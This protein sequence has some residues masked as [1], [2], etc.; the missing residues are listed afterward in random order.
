M[1]KG[2]G[3]QRR[4]FLR[5][6]CSLL[7]ATVSATLAALVASPVLSP[8][9]R[10]A[11]TRARTA[12]VRLPELMAGETQPLTVSI[13]RDDGWLRSR[14]HRVVYCRR[15]NDD[16]YTVLSARC[17]HLGCTVA[18]DP[19]N[20]Q[21]KCPCHGGVYDEEGR[22]IAGPPPAPLSRLPCYRNDDHLAI[23]LD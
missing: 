2:E 5:L 11:P 18:W 13:E 6:L 21:F 17:T 1:K 10:S 4:G 20:K 23:T 19:I 8:L 7:S 3:V 12:R 22:V 16:G 15:D 9:I 14:N